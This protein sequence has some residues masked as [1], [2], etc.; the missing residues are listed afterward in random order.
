MDLQEKGVAVYMDRGY[1][2]VKAKGY[3]ATIQRGIKGY[4]GGIR[5]KLRNNREV[6]EGLCYRK[7]SLI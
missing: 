6:R 2:G 5:D 7:T 4:L 1:F 3:D